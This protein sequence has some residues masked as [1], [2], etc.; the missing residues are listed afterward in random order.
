MPGSTPLASSPTAP[1][2]TRRISARASWLRRNLTQRL[3]DGRIRG[4]ERG[5]QTSRHRR[6]YAASTAAGSPPQVGST[7][8][9]IS[10]HLPD[11]ACTRTDSPRSPRRPP[12]AR[13]WSLVAALL[14]DR[15]RACGRR[16]VAPGV[17]LL[18]MRSLHLGRLPKPLLAAS[19]SKEPNQEPTTAGLEPRPPTPSVRIR[20]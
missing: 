18:Q 19:L 5:L 2:S 12:L 17:S 6:E 10:L 4:R 16:P 9:T 14:A 13:C 1:A 15:R 11:I 8:M 3:S 7:P 20:R